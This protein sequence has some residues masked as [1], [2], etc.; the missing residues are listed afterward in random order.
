MKCGNM[1]LQ[2][3]KGAVSKKENDFMIQ[4][5]FHLIKFLASDLQESISDL[6]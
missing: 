6:F 5:M 1:E 2:K 3:K 4:G